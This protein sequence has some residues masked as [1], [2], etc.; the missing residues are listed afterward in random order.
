M[1]PVSLTEKYHHH[2]R[3]DVDTYDSHTHMC[4][5]WRWCIEVKDHLKRVYTGN[6]CPKWFTRFLR[7]DL[8]SMGRVLL[9]RIFWDCNILFAPS[10]LITTL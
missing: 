8:L 2:K 4:I 10:A 7:S 9:N 3:K 1:K 5:L 6:R